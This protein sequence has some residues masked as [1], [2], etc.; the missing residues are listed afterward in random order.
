MT[1]FRRAERPIVWLLVAG[2]LLL[3][4]F[5]RLYDLRTMP[6]GLSQD[7]VGNADISLGLLRGEHAPFLSGTSVPFCEKASES[8]RPNIVADRMGVIHS[9][10]FGLEME[11]GTAGALRRFDFYVDNR[12]IL[13]GA[14]GST[15]RRLIG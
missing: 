4:A 5:F 8:F 11:Y 6:W 10:P 1:E 3:A 2:I 9:E 12:P 15:D 13:A 14:V 7:E